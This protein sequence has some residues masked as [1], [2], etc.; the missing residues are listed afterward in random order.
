MMDYDNMKLSELEREA[1]KTDNKL[2]LAIFRKL[3]DAL[4]EPDLDKLGETT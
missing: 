3:D 1:W 2:A 4:D